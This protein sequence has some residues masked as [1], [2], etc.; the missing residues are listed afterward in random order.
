MQ[1]GALLVASDR[2]LDVVKGRSASLMVLLTR[3]LVL[4]RLTG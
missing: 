2:I 3:G 1:A 4:E